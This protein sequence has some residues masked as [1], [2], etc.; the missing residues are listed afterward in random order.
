M[1]GTVERICRP[2]DAS[3]KGR[4][5]RGRAGVPPGAYG[6]RRVAR[7]RTLDQVRKFLVGQ[8]R[9]LEDAAQE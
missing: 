1:I 7:R 5:V 2:G 4:R 9:L 3:R 8:S 6:V